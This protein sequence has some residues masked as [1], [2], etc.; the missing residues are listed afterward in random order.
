MSAIR[1]EAFYFD[2]HKGRRF[3]ILHRPASGA[4]ERGGIVHVHAFAEEMNK[5]R[6]AVALTARALAEAGWSVLLIDLHGCGDSSG[7]FGDA[8]WDDW[9]RDALAGVDLLRQRVEGDV[10]LWGH[11][12]GCLIASQASAQ[13]SGAIPLLLWQPITSGRLH[14]AQFLRLKVAGAA[15][16]AGGGHEN[17]R[18]LRDRL[19]AG[20]SIEIAGYLVRSELARGLEQALLGFESQQ[21][22]VRWCEVSVDGTPSHALS[23]GELLAAARARGVSVRSTV[24][25]GLPFWQTVETTTSAALVAETLAVLE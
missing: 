15:L 13:R 11:R 23:S 9:V 1:T 7:D 2:G 8:I 14:L 10:W 25:V 5:S 6:R 12:A 19:I 24:A 3:C 20:E 17:T 22:A 4:V 21:A 18:S 16:A